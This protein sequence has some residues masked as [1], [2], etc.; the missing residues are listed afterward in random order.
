MG[1]DIRMAAISEEEEGT[2]SPGHWE[3]WLVLFL[4]WGWLLGCIPTRIIHGVTYFCFL[5]LPYVEPQ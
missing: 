5:Q 2:P 1:L 3:Q 4:T